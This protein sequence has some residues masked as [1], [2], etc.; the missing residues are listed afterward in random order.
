MKVSSNGQFGAHGCP[1]ASV[2]LKQAPEMNKKDGEV[3]M[4]KQKNNSFQRKNNI[5]TKM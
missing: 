2:N 5:L 4:T 3:I 1:H